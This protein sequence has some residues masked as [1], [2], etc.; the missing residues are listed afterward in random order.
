[1]EYAQERNIFWDAI[2]GLAIL[3]VLLGHS[4]QNCCS[5]VGGVCFNNPLYRV[6]Y[7]FHMPL[8]MIICGFFFCY[9]V[10]RNSVISVIK[11]KVISI[12]VPI[13]TFAVIWFPILYSGPFS[14]LKVAHF[15]FSSLTILWFLCQILL[16]MAT[17]LYVRFL[18]K[19]NCLVYI[20]ICMLTMF[21][22]NIGGLERYS[23]ML[24]MFVLGYWLNKYK[25]EPFIL[26]RY[27]LHTFVICLLLYV[28][29]I[30]VYD[31]DSFIYTSKT[32]LFGVNPPWK[33]LAINLYR[34]FIGIV[35][36]LL[37]LSGGKIIYCLSFEKSRWRLIWTGFAFLGYFSLGIYCFQT[38]FWYFYPL[39][40]HIGS[41]S[42]SHFILSIILGTILS[43]IICTA[44]SFICSKNKFT[45]LLL[46]GNR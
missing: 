9:T 36:S 46:L 10:S 16:C 24:P 3:L 37:I 35:G 43:L 27:K 28:V 26:S 20:L 34:I 1:M 15:I 23:F 39:I 5:L 12:L 17:V 40:P 42:A 45:R 41:I 13:V 33:Q 25:W 22:P 6:I 44:F 7:S 31:N 4:I 29:L 8:F 21:L 14:F 18:L 30:L 32:Y 11:K 2:K 38:L 19:D